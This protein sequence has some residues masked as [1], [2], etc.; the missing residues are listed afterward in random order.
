MS[1]HRLQALQDRADI[2]EVVVAVAIAQDAHD[3]DSLAACFAA[4]ATYIH[5]KGEL[6]GADAIVER[7]R[8]AL[9]ALDASQHLIGSISVSVDGDEGTATSYF[10]A[11]HVRAD[12][13]AGSL[14]IIAGT[15]RDRL[16]RTDGRWQIVERHQSYTWRDGN[17]EVVRR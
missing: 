9:S 12:A 15:Y 10:Q 4:D 14:F 17:P 6:H 16:R 7:S 5:P 11:Q 2:H 1:D 3:W 13:S 8:G